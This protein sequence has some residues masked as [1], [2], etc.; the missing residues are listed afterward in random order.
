M[1]LIGIFILFLH[2]ISDVF[3]AL[4][5]SYNDYKHKNKI[6]LNI[7]YVLGFLGWIGFRVIIFS[8]C[9]VYAVWY[10]FIT[11]IHVLP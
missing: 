5:R 7:F 10:Q 3:L 4:G 8:Y 9:C 6:L 1:W 2:D 11:R